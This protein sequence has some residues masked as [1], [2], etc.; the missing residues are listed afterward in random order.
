VLLVATAYFLLFERASTLGTYPMWV[1]QL[2]GCCV[3][4]C[5][6]KPSRMSVCPFWKSVFNGALMASLD[7]W[8]DRER[9]AVI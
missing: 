2:I 7:G 3:G 9:M 1:V 4:C 8:M 6:L 5:F